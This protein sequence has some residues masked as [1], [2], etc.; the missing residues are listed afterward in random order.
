MSN[1]NLDNALLSFQSFNS[2]KNAFCNGVS[3]QAL[4]KQYYLNMHLLA[5][6]EVPIVSISSSTTIKNLYT[7]SSN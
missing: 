5:F 3:L 7:W 1:P 2:Y 4:E 6:S